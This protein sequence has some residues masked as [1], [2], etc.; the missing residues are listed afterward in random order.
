MS[1]INDNNLI[2]RE[3]YIG[4]IHQKFQYPDLII[5]I[6]KNIKLL[7]DVNYN[8]KLYLKVILNIQ[9]FL[10]NNTNK[11]KLY[12]IGD[13]SSKE[14]LHNKDY[15]YLDNL[16][17]ILF[18]VKTRY[19]LDRLY[20]FIINPYDN[21]QR[22]SSIYN[23][24]NSYFKNQQDEYII[25]EIKEEIIVEER[26]KYKELLFMD[27]QPLNDIKQKIIDQFIILFIEVNKKKLKNLSIEIPEKNDMLY[28]FLNNFI[29]LNEENFR[30]PIQLYHAEKSLNARAPYSY[31]E[32]SKLLASKR[33]LKKNIDDW[34]HPVMNTNKKQFLEYNLEIN[35]SKL[36]YLERKFKFLKDI[37][38]EKK[39]ENPFF[40]LVDEL[41][42]NPDMYGYIL[43]I[44]HILYQIFF[45]RGDLSIDRVNLIIFHNKKIF[46][47]FNL[48]YTLYTQ[49]YLDSEKIRSVSEDDFKSLINY[50]YTNNSDYN[51]RKNI[52]NKKIQE[53]QNMPENKIFF[54]NKIDIFL[55]SIDD[56][57][58]HYENFME[59]ICRYIEF[60]N[61]IEFE[62]HS[63]VDKINR[64]IDQ[65]ID[66]RLEGPLS[67]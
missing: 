52:Q 54:E 56:I 37:I 46:E 18:H 49:E 48:P 12:D 31:E 44:N 35:Q 62:Q 39:I 64:Y 34:L 14:W 66:N 10:L 42:K 13:P 19:I 59:F 67:F 25:K 43:F 65:N 57:I 28:P 20:N 61:S 58:K 9:Y 60:C 27:T 23:N 30:T 22:I 36:R 51:T 11:N 3:M 24:F 41:K 63:V 55:K 32:N 1:D 40:L 5:D 38:V 21:F 16:L 7:C 8:N 50:C 26:D 29:Y 2:K 45:D 15:H 33:E 4:N 6:K 17:S 47:F 53:F